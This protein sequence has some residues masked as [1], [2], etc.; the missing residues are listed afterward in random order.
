MIINPTIIKH[1][2]N[3][4]IRAYSYFETQKFLHDAEESI[5]LQENKMTKNQSSK[6]YANVRKISKN[7]SYFSILFSL[8]I[9]VQWCPNF[10]LMQTNSNFWNI[11]VRDNYILHFTRKLTQHNKVNWKLVQL[12]YSWLIEVLL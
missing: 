6:Q 4:F 8:I 1:K 3:K 10:N 5:S 7:K 9:L 2:N 12:N 11:L